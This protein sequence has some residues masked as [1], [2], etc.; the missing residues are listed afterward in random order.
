MDLISAHVGQRHLT[1]VTKP[2]RSDDEAGKVFC[3][4]VVRSVED[5]TLPIGA[6]DESHRVQLELM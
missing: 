1:S 3:R 5:V 4:S 2:S 6:G